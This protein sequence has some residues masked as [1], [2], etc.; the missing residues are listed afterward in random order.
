MTP[1]IPYNISYASPRTI[2]HLIPSRSNVDGCYRSDLERSGLKRERLTYPRGIISPY[3]SR[4]GPT[5]RLMST[6]AEG[7]ACDL[8]ICYQTMNLRLYPNSPPRSYTVH[9]SIHGQSFLASDLVSLKSRSIFQ[10][11]IFLDRE[12]VRT[13]CPDID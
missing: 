12:R 10:S 8:D 11:D 9:S 1:S 13:M 6:P 7:Q 3:T 5:Y 4:K 2:T